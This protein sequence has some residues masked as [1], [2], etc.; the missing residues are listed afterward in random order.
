MA[1][2]KTQL[3]RNAFVRGLITEA[4]PLT[5]PENA[6]IDEVNF[7]LNR[8]GSRQRRL[9][10]DFE[11][12]YSL[13]QTGGT[14]ATF[15]EYN[16][17][18]Y[19]WDNVNN[20]PTISFGVVQ[21]GNGILF[22]DLFAT[23]LSDNVKNSGA[24]FYINA[25]NVGFDIAGTSQMDFASIDGTLIV[26]SSEFDNP[27][28][29]S[30][31]SDT[32][33][34]NGSQIT[35]N[36][37][38][39]WGIADG[40]KVNE[41]PAT[42]TDEHKYNLLNQGW[43]LNRISASL[44]N[45][46]TQIATSSVQTLAQAFPEYFNIDGTAKYDY[47]STSYGDW[48][49]SNQ[50]SASWVY[51]YYGTDGT[52]PFTGAAVGTSTST[53]YYPSNADIYHVGKK[54]DSNGVMAFDYAQLE[55]ASFGSSSAPRGKFIIGAFQRGLDR[56][57]QTGITTLLDDTDAGNISAVASFAGRIFYS[58]VTSQRTESDARNPNY[59]GSL[60]FSQVI[61]YQDQFGMCYQ[62]ADPT[63]EEISDLIATDGGT[64]KIPEAG[65]ILRLI[66]K[67]ASLI[68]IADNGVWQITGPDNVFRADDFSITQVTNVGCIAK[69]SVINA[70]GT[71]M[72]WSNAG[73]YMLAADQNG[74][75][76][77]QNMTETTIQTL[78]N[79]IPSIGRANAVGHFDFAGRKIAWLY[80][81]EDSYDGVQFR[82][83]Y[84]KQLVFDTVLQ[85]WY[86][87]EIFEDGTLHSPFVAGYMETQLF[88]SSTYEEPIV[89]NADPV[90]V[91]G[92]DV[93]ISTRV[94]TRGA[95]Q[96][97]YLVWK[98]NANT[99]FY[100]VSF[101][102]YG[103]ADFKDWAVTDAAAY[104]VTGHEL[105]G[106][107]QRSKLSNYLTLHFKRTESGFTDTGNGNLEAIGASGCLCRVQWDF[108][109]SAASGKWGSQ[110]QGYRLKRAYFPTGI[111]DT[112]DYGW[113]V[114][115]TKNRLRGRGRAISF[116][117]DTEA[118]KDCYL[119]GWAM[120]VEGQ[121]NV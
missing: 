22:F 118:E 95:S 89:N 14:P 62:E 53:G 8:D 70:E 5:F 20:D 78:Y 36:V 79:E 25:A 92:E 39:I 110:F 7:V 16:I 13:V 42:L 120:D 84:N 117:F 50:N 26:A 65:E 80:N 96:T 58:G 101:A 90:Q 9:G 2:A 17:T 76:I 64:I 82:K 45:S 71:I 52:V 31:N 107:T 28:A 73:I 91:G 77:A 109:N 116:R 86:I 54:I 29:I 48:Y 99:G 119:L 47:T 56:Q 93:V 106:D 49:S 75:L 1:R 43:P 100:D 46:T 40:L 61:K 74:D 94:R 34:F 121:T 68:V 41:R 113:E 111:N 97:K 103:N 112:F 57:S 60:F 27:V 66:V 105:F 55:E 10:M 114:I 35:I 4:S 37:R 21:V 23:T 32:D 3:E 19:K 69:S 51:G 30:Y 15:P 33:E 6:S 72:Y 102:R 108:A 98:Y 115:S 88:N 63:S 85:A 44:G 67:D 59:S 104:L 87:L 11:N 12:G 24:P 83:K 38:D 81:D 18:T